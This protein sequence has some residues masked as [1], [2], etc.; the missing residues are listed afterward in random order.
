MCQAERQTRGLGWEHH[1]R[2]VVLGLSPCYSAARNHQ[3][4]MVFRSR[5]SGPELA[6][7]HAHKAMMLAP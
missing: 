6:L 2:H 1:S 5:H 4:T 7:V 3:Q